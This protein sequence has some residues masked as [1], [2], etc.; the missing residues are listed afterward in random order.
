MYPCLLQKQISNYI[1]IIFFSNH[2]ILHVVKYFPL[3][4]GRSNT[5][6]K[7]WTLKYLLM[8]N[9]EKATFIPGAQRNK[10]VG[11]YKS[12]AGNCYGS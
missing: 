8:F 6:V 3:G 9:Y 2:T 1:N 12:M 5:Y 11:F 7:I 10:I 4:V